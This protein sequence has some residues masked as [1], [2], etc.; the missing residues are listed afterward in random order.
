MGANYF[1]PENAWRHLFF[2]HGCT[3]DEFY[4]DGGLK[5]NIEA[6]DPVGAEAQRL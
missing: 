5:L 2:I 1:T 6:A 3:A 4:T